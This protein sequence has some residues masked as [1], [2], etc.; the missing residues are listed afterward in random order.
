M[1]ALTR[2]RVAKYIAM[3]AFQ[4]KRVIRM[5]KRVL[6][7]AAVSLILATLLILT[8]AREIA[9][10]PIEILENQHPLYAPRGQ[11]TFS[12][13]IVARENFEKVR[14]KFSW[15]ASK[16]LDMTALIDPKREYLPEDEPEDV[17][18]NVIKLSWFKNKTSS[19]GILPEEYTRTTSIEGSEF[20]TVV[21]DYT[22]IVEHLSGSNATL[23]VPL[24]YVAMMNGTG[25]S[26]YMEGYT[27]FI[28]SPRT[29]IRILS[30]AHNEDETRY[31]PD[32]QVWEESGRLPLSTAP[33]GVLEFNSVEKDDTMTVIFTV[34]SV[35]SSDRSPIGMM[36]MIKIY[37][38]G[39][40]YDQPIINMIASAKG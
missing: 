16:I 14:L 22:S 34:E 7:I 25:S 30:I 27:D 38:D 39:E 36:Q 5:D 10:Q 35:P 4:Q 32:S 24:I 18:G 23:G 13:S 3:G 17:F 21:Y 2:S 26:I 28:S 37:L 15:A 29:N 33:R 20:D 11:A 8:V 12:F 19:L 6:G 9:D 40:L 1:R 31:I